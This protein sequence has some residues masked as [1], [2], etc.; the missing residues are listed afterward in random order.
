MS[1]VLEQ[2]SEKTCEPPKKNFVNFSLIFSLFLIILLDLNFTI[3]IKFYIIYRFIKIDRK[4]TR[5]NSSHDV[6]SRMPSSA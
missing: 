4:S 6:I 3:C 5:L 1:I 2:V